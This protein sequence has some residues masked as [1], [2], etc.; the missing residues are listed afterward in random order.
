MGVSNKWELCF[1]VVYWISTQLVEIRLSRIE[2][3][4]GYTFNILGVFYMN[5]MF[6]E[7]TLLEC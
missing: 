1:L 3:Y 4:A 2:S 5:C 6:V 7:G